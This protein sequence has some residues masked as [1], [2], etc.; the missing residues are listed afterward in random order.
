MSERIKVIN[1]FF[2]Q[3]IENPEMFGKLKEVY[4][5]IK[6]MEKNSYVEAKLIELEERLLH[7]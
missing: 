7:F 6:L 1:E 3:I 2:A 4:D 5:I